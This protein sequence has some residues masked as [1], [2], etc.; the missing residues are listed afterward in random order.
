MQADPPIAR[1]RRIRAALAAGS[2]VPAEDAAWLA[3]ALARYEA[4]APAGTD[5]DRALG[6]VQRG[7][8]AWWEADAIARRDAA[9]RELRVRFYP[10]APAREA[11]RLIA[12]DATRY[13][14]SGWRQDRG[15]VVQD[16]RRRLLGEVLAPGAV[17]P[18][19]RR[20][21]AILGR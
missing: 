7:G 20:M 18:S 1:L 4:E 10:E 8:R 16:E 21:R 15:Q 19:E 2:L 14:A 12:R 13:A 3:E 5:L 17:L 6:L 9:L 11:A